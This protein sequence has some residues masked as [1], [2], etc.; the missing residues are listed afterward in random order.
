L[1]PFVDERDDGPPLAFPTDLVPTRSHLKPAW[2]MAY[3]S[4]PAISVTE[5]RALFAE[6]SRTGGGIVLYHDPVAETAWAH[7]AEGTVEM[8]VGPGSG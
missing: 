6:L 8:V 7:A 4:R 5:K 3:D 2:V 1:I